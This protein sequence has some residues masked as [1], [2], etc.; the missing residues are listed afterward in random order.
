[1]P[2]LINFKAWDGE[3]LI[4][5]EL[6]SVLAGELFNSEWQVMQFSGVKDQDGVEIYNGHIL[7]VVEDCIHPVP[8]VA[9]LKAGNYSVRHE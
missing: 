9:P 6:G 4:S 7:Q 1:L 3:Q 2:T 8:T 5:F